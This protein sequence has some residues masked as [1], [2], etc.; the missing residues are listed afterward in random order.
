V[1]SKCVNLPGQ[2]SAYIRSVEKH[3]AVAEV[4]RHASVVS[5]MT[6]GDLL[7][8]RIAVDRREMRACVHAGQQPCGTYARARTQFEKVAARFRRREGP[9]K[10]TGLRF[11]R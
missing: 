5:E 10:R 2:A 8:L 4:K 7:R 6:P 11:G 1:C 3:A 9:K